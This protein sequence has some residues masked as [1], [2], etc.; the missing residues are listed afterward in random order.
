[1]LWGALDGKKLETA[2]SQIQFL[3]TNVGAQFQ[4]DKID[5]PL[6]AKFA[7]LAKELK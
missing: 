1:M 2:R 7:W 5:E 3:I 4:D 6:R